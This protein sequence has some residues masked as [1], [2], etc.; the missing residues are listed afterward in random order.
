MTTIE[1]INLDEKKASFVM[2]GA[3][4]LFGDL[5]DMIH[6]NGGRLKKV[7]LNV[8]DVER[9]GRLSTRGRIDRM[10]YKVETIS[11]EDFTPEEGEKYLIGF[12]SYQMIP[13]RG[14][15]KEKFSLKF[16]NLIH[17]TAIVSPS[18]AMGEGC[19][20]CAGVIIGSYA[21]LGNHVV[22]N[23]GATVGHDAYLEDYSFIGPSG[24][25]CSGVIAQEGSSIFAGAK[26]IERKVIG[27][28][29]QVG[30]GA[31][32]LKDVPSGVLV[33]G[34]PAT[35]KKHLGAVVN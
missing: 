23:R 2:L 12:K 32:C 17:P 22:I 28:R 7:V 35:V 13:L 11:L 29:S 19:I 20:L 6:L 34:V 33:V 18:V 27:A 14:Y 30:A 16:E 15:L 31:V 26:V 9:K 8:P 1:P 5:V 21:K 25:I 4:D 3:G 24:V 10:P